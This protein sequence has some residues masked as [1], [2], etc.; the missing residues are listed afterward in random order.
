MT[1]AEKTLAQLEQELQEAASI[2]DDALR[3]S[4]RANIE[5]STARN[6]LNAAQKAIDDKLDKMRKA[7]PAGDWRDAQHRREGGRSGL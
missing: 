5:E 3:A 1:N 4:R 6:R 2:Y 7:A